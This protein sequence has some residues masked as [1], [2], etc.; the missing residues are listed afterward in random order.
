[1]MSYAYVMNYVC[2]GEVDIYE[3]SNLKGDEMKIGLA[4]CVLLGMGMIFSSSICVT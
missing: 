4:L 1:M 2:L 3:V